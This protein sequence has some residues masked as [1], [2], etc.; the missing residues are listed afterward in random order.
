MKEIFLTILIFGISLPLFSQQTI[1]LEGQIS[2]VTS[3]HIYVKFTSTK[4]IETGDTL[5]IKEGNEYLAAL[6]VK[7]KSSLSCVSTKI[8]EMAYKKGQKVYHLSLEEKGQETNNDDWVENPKAQSIPTEVNVQ[9]PEDETESLVPKEQLKQSIKGRLSAASYTSFQDLNSIADPRMKYN[10]SFKGENIGG[11]HFD[12]ESYVSFR[13]EINHWDEVAGDINRAFKIY[14]LAAT[15]HKNDFEISLGRKVIRSISNIGAVDGIHFSYSIN[16]FSIGAIAGSRPDV[17]DYGF[18]LGLPE[19]GAYMVHKRS[20]QHGEIRSTLGLFEQRAGNTTDR[21]FIYLQHSNSAIKKL[22]IFAS[23][24]IDLYKNF[25]GIASNELSI[26]SLY[27]SARYRINRKYSFFLSYDNRKNVIYYESYKNFIDQ[28]IEQETRQ[29]FRARF[30]A[31]PFRFGSI[32]ISGTYRYQKNNLSPSKNANIYFNYSRLPFIK[33]SSS[34]SYTY[35]DTYYLNSHI[36]GLRLRKD[37]WK[38]KVNLGL[39]YRWVNYIYKNSPAS[40]QNHIAGLD[41]GWNLGRNIYFSL[42]HEVNINHTQNYQ[43]S[44]I[45]LTKRFR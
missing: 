23:C 29:G 28:L 19:L 9:I 20:T 41:L 6:A 14:N 3:Q 11:S 16:D 40:L 17:F 7:N 12:L 34:L 39:N 22:Y 1:A 13:H 30:V 18:N 31:R 4:N 38:G 36:A 26:T 37:L 42:N 44:Y 24:E 5:F 35:L 32:G 15:Y 45:K 21:R 25:E 8:A 27:L 43:R 2:Y 33:A 10:L